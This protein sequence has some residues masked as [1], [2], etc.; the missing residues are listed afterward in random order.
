MEDPT[1]VSTI[2]ENVLKLTCQIENGNSSANS[3]AEGLKIAFTGELEKNSANLG[4]NAVWNKTSK[5]NRLVSVNF[6][7]T[8]HIHFFLQPKYLAVNF[9][10]FYWKQA[11]AAAGTDAGKA[12]ILR[13]VLFPK[14]FDIFEFCTDE[15]K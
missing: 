4:R 10:R 14:V 2:R 7:L 13:S 9:L 11:S 6:L 12:K 3:I 8:N 5:M 15:L 1:E